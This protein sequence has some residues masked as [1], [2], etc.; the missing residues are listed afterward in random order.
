MSRTSPYNSKSKAPQS[1]LSNRLIDSSFFGVQ[2]KFND[3]K[4][5]E[6]E[7]T[8]G[9]DVV[10]RQPKPDNNAPQIQKEEPEGGVV[11]QLPAAQQVK[12]ITEV[13]SAALARLEVSHPQIYHHLSKAPLNG[14]EM[15]ILSSEQKIVEG[16]EAQLYGLLLWVEGDL[17][18][19]A[20]PHF[21]DALGFETIGDFKLWMMR[22]KLPQRISEDNLY[23]ALIHEGIHLLL[24][25]DR[26]KEALA[27]EGVATTLADSPY[28]ASF[29][30]YMKFAKESRR[31]LYVEMAL[32]IALMPRFTVGENTDMA[33][34]TSEVELVIK[35]FVEEKYA[36]D[37]ETYSTESKGND[38][39]VWVAV[40]YAKQVLTVNG[41]TDN[42]QIEEVMK[43]L[44][45]LYNDI[46]SGM[47]AQ[48]APTP[49]P[50]T[51]PK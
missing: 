7:G 19:D 15:N 39:N 48:N 30:D 12:P 21:Q 27:T 32:Q 37:L 43:H 24:S 45:Y 36:N 6:A 4:S 8:G 13:F 17:G 42:V 49:T 40:N 23:Q 51:Q 47:A 22:I 25:I 35:L 29:S 5:K 41:V 18:V 11:D 10:Q 34:L 38:L 31:W 3:Q 44:H 33:K 16:S 20:N 14:A 26:Y 46:D 50:T 1:G 9:T 2:A 28:K